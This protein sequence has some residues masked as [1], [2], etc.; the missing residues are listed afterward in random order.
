MDHCWSFIA[1]HEDIESVSNIRLNITFQA[2]L[3]VHSPWLLPRT[4]LNNT[5][6][7]PFVAPV[8]AIDSI[9]GLCPQLGGLTI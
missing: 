2:A 9:V 1:L 3:S 4:P 5:P 7:T 6:L 8:W